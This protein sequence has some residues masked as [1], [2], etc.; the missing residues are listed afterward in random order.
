MGMLIHTQRGKKDV[1]ICMLIIWSVSRS[2]SSLSFLR[3]SR[4]NI[5]FQ[6]L[7][8]FAYD[9]EFINGLWCKDAVTCQFDEGGLFVT[10]TI[11]EILFE[12]FSD[13][14][15]LKYLNLKYSSYNIS[16]H[17]TE[18]STL[19]MLSADELYCVREDFHCTNGVYLYLPNG[20]KK[21][22][23]YGV[24]PKDEYFAPFFEVSLTKGDLLWRFSANET[25][26]NDSKSR[27]QH[28]DVVEI[29]NPS[30]AAHPDWHHDDID[31]HKYIQCQKRLL[32]GA[33]NMFVSCYDMINTGSKRFK[34]ATY[35]E[36]FRGNGSI[37][38][39][40]NDSNHNGE[41]EV[42]GTTSMRYPAYL[43]DGFQNYPYI[44]F[45]DGDK[46]TKYFDIKTLP[47]F[48]KESSLR[49]DLSQTGVEFEFE[50]NVVLYFPIP[51]EYDKLLTS[52]SEKISLRRFVEDEATW[53]KFRAVG[54]PL[55]SYGMP[56]IIPKGNCV[57][58]CCSSLIFSGLI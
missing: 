33:A 22:F 12:G 6:Q 42:G 47:L 51:D 37:V 45:P 55:D 30:W 20:Q 56:Y 16:Y 32:F 49:L 43:Y 23:K 41:L 44:F 4:G 31:F 38:Y 9:L 15:T 13:A 11:R 27:L 50:K 35:L 39:L 3:C 34:R 14:F 29:Y 28:E 21:Y 7:I 57:S 53:D 5:L 54:T 10:K 2:Y 52:T 17:C 40:K 48:D 18:N 58:C 8:Q 26:A 25:I 24:T 36:E 19:A 1:L 46:S